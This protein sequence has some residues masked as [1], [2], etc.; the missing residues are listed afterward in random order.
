MAI[1]NKAFHSRKWRFPWSIV[2]WGISGVITRQAIRLALSA[3]VDDDGGNGGGGADMRRDK[4]AETS[5]F[6]KIGAG[7]GA[8]PDWPSQVNKLF[9]REGKQEYIGMN[10]VKK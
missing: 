6:K 10:L 1:D 5:L 7:T 4:L 2:C 8:K 9:H 3:E